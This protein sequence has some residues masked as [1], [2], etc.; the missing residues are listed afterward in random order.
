[1]IMTKFYNLKFLALLLTFVF[2]GFE[3]AH[4]QII[5]FDNADDAAYTSGWIS[6]SKGGSGFGAWEI[7]SAANAGVFIGNPANDG[8]GTDGIG[9]NAFAMYANGTTYINARRSFNADMQIGDEISFYWAMNWDANAGSKGFD[10]KSGTSSVFNINNGNFSPAITT[11]SDTA[12]RV[13]GTKPIFVK[14]K[15]LSS[16]LYSFSLTGRDGNES[17]STTINST[18]AVNG[19]DFYIGNQNDNSAQKGNRNVY[20]NNFQITSN[21][22]SV[23]NLKFEKGF[24]VYPNPVLRG[25]ALQLEIINLAAGKYTVSLYNLAGVRLQQTV[26]A[27][28]GGKGLQP[29]QLNET[30]APGVYI[31]EISGAGKRENMKLI[32]Q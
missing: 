14:L 3:F 24:G 4:S 5:A 27:H 13:Y 15:R 7:T 9:T 28:K 12:L 2:A 16:D 11:S 20:F 1:M 31:A 22:S 18:F 26:F 23:S 21:A 19:I 17:Y 8:M 6:G 32:V 29:V 10:F 25:A 30:L